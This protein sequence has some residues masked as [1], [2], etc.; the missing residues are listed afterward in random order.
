LQ[1]PDSKF[2]VIDTITTTN[3]VNSKVSK[4]RHR[5]YSKNNSRGNF[6]ERV[7]RFATTDVSLPN[8][9]RKVLFKRI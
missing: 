4:K 5:Y 3:T 1:K 9:D 6:V 7:S 2:N 8:L